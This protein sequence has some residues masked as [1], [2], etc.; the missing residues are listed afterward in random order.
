M[1]TIAHSCVLAIAL[2]CAACTSTSQKPSAK[3][4]QA[5]FNNYQLLGLAYDPAIANLYCDS[6]RMLNTRTYPD[7]QK[8]LIEM[9]APEWKALIITAM[10]VAKARGDYSTF[11][12]VTYT[13]E[14]DN[15]RI[16][17]T[18]YSALKKY[19]SPFSL[20]VGQCDDQDW[21]ILEEVGESRP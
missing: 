11:S 20:L 10:P 16:T 5:L 2:L 17:A 9:K 7:G 14:G 6:G 13:P 8:R 3:D 21:A 18:R 15:I 1:K 19:S 4:A 12:N